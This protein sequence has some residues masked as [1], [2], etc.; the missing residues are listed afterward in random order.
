MPSICIPPWAGGN[1]R[2]EVL[3]LVFSPHEPP[4]EPP[5]FRPREQAP[6][7]ATVV[8]EEGHARALVKRG[9]WQARRA[10]GP[11]AE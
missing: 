6:P 10:V 3:L 5:R 9:R 2:Q 11:G 4:Q 8:A 7:A 1:P